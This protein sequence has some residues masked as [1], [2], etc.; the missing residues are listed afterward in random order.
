MILEGG[1]FGKLL[2]LDKV[3]R[4]ELPEELVSS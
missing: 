4:K 1:A 3:M 2:A